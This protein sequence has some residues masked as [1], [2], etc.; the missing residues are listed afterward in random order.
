MATVSVGGSTNTVIAD[1][2]SAT[3]TATKEDYV[4]VGCTQGPPGQA[5]GAGS[6]T[7]V[8]EAEP[9]G[10]TPGDG[11]FTPSTTRLQI[12]N[13]NMFTELSV[14]E[15]DNAATVDDGYF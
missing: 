12:Y 7:Y 10:I 13:S 2:A 4:V 15:A 6:T 1:N 3:I 14:T 8:A 9:S 5:G 11:W